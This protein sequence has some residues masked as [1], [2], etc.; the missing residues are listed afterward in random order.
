MKIRRNFPLKKLNSFSID[1]K[2]NYF[3]EI[4]SEED[5]IDF[6]NNKEFKNREI[7][8]LGGGNNILFTT[9]FTGVVIY[10]NILHKSIKQATEDVA[11]VKVGAGEEWDSFV[12]WTVNKNLYGIE[13]LSSIP[14]TVGASPVQNIG[15]YGVEVKDT[16]FKVEAFC[17]KTGKIIEFNNSDCNF[18]YRNSIF[19]EKYK[20]KYII[21][22]VYFKLS[23]Q[24]SFKIQYGDIIKE[25]K[26]FEVLDINTLRQTIINIRDSKLPKPEYIPN[27]GSFFKNPIVSKEKHNQ[28]KVEFPDIVS[29][30]IDDNNYKLAAGWLI[31]F[32]GWK[33]VSL[34]NVGVHKKQAL[35]LIN[36]NNAKG[37]EILYLADIICK[38]ISL[39]FDV[40]LEYEVNIV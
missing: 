27:A 26:N 14:G 7:L 34:T 15:A 8:I 37:A 38:A 40:E 19:K 4:Y 25:L 1:V 13:N 16:I 3:V 9:D 39:K 22:Y 23:K 21:T 20:N 35:V 10:V 6:I 2:A 12:E 24:A 30:K 18:S 31:D 11:I 32:A 36:I 28:L 33:G 5:L 29:Y 17:L